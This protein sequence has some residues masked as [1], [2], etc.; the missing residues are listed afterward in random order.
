IGPG[1][2]IDALGREIV[3]GQ[4]QIEPVP[5][6][7]GESDGSPVSYDL[8]VSYPPDADLEEAETRDGICL[9]RGV[10]RLREEPEFCWV[11]L[12]RDGQGNLHPKNPKLQTD[13]KDGLKIL[14]A[15]IEVLNCQLNGPV[16]LA[17]RRSARPAT[18]PY[19]ACG[20]ARPTLWSD[21]IVDGE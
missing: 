3:L 18:Q 2:A 5:P 12:E 1:Y 20:E 4:D 6:V 19:V 13:I 21:W 8:T 7:A 9:P 10:V 15:R 14:L 17:E 11:R 16:S